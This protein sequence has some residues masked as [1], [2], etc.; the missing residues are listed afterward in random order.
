MNCG[1]IGQSDCVGQMAGVSEE[2]R[3]YYQSEGDHQN[4]DASIVLHL[5][6]REQVGTC[7]GNDVHCEQL[8]IQSK[9][10]KM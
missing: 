8:T 1:C 7:W 5:I 3:L 2:F 9:N 4:Q 10:E 6:F